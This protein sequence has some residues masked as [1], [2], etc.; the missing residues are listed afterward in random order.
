MLK[1]KE[2]LISHF[3]IL[4]KCLIYPPPLPVWITSRIVV[5]KLVNSLGLI[6]MHVP[7]LQVTPLLAFADFYRVIIRKEAGS[8]PKVRVGSSSSSV[9]LFL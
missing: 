5:V 3:I 1:A 6:D 2:W 7:V 9:L 8:H 4:K